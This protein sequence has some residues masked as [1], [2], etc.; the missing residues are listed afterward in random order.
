MIEDTMGDEKMHY[1]KQAII[2]AAGF[3]SR[4]R[5]ITD[6]TPKPLVKVNGKRMIDTC[7]DGLM[8]NGINEIYVV[9]GYLKEQFSVITEKYPNVKLIEN[10]YYDTCNNI[11]SL[12]VAREYLEDSII[13]SG[14][15]IIK[16][17]DILKPEFDYSGYACAWTDEDAV[18]WTLT[19]ENGFGTACCKEGG[20][21]TWEMYAISRW[22]AE[23]GR[24]LKRQL[25]KE[26]IEN[27]NTS[28]F[29]DDL[30][31]FCYFDEYKMG[32]AEIKKED[33][34]EIDS[35]DE[36]IAVDKSYAKYKK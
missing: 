10:P 20:R 2:T 27:N 36:L 17:Y 12:Y 14:D 30:P 18:E 26:F 35:L 7:I 4:M 21:H 15:L 5:P 28:I 11:S 22:T 9:V 25:E 3:G 1:A 32:Y 13:V 31:L 24:K 16:N 34:I 19:V 6:T 23:D 33:L 29:W 8:A